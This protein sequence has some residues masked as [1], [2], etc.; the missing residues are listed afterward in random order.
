MNIQGWTQGSRKTHQT[1]VN[2][3]AEYLYWLTSIEDS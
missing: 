2:M 3:L 1:I